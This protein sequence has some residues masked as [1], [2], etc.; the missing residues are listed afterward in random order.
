MST[1]HLSD[2]LLQRHLDGVLSPAES[3]PVEAHLRECP[4]CAALRT[5]YQELF[6]GLSVLA[7]PPPP[8][9]RFAEAVLARVIAH[10]REVAR[11]RWV[12]LGT[13][14]GS[15]ALALACFAAAGSHVWAHEVTSWS[16]A[17]IALSR[18]LHVAVD[19]LGSL[20]AAVRLPLVATSA[21]LSLPLLLVLYRAL[22]ERTL[23]A[24]A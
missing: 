9:P 12:A 4:D 3:E 11:E 20:F 22:P 16:A 18:E 1:P 21:A 19:V 2:E 7:P 5:E 17:L 13:F 14:A 8:P 10:E 6:G 23:P 24:S 15:V